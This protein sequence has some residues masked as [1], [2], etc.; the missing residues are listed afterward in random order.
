MNI[1]I[2]CIPLTYPAKKGRHFKIYDQ[3]KIISVQVGYLDRAL[4]LL[5]YNFQ[6]SLLII[7]K[8]R[9]IKARLHFVVIYV[10]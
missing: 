7:W 5:K 9:S 4:I 2:D 10:V 1:K 8:G 3:L 6:G